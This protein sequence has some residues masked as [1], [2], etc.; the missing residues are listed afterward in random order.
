[1]G[2]PIAMATKALI[3]EDSEA[4]QTMLQ[5]SLAAVAVTADIVQ[6]AEE[7]KHF[8][9]THSVDLVV[10]DAASGGNTGLTLLDKLKPEGGD[11]A[12]RSNRR[13]Q[14]ELG[15]AIV[16]LREKSD[17]APAGN[18]LVMADLVKPFTGEELRAAFAAAAPH[19]KKIQAAVSPVSYEPAADPE[20]E[21]GRR[22]LSYGE[23]YVFFSENPKPAYE[24]LEV[25]SR[26]GYSV[27]LVTAG[28]AKVARERFGL[29]KG[30]EIFTL[31]DTAESK[32]TYPL[33]T[34][35]ATVKD[36][37]DKA[38]HPVLAIDDLDA[39]I[40]RTGLDLAFTA[41][42]EILGLRNDYRFTLLVAVDGDSLSRKDRELL[43]EMM[44][45]YRNSEK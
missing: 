6:N 33:G 27:L 45:V 23:S 24:A 21:L 36:F 3:V 25:F 8:I 9:Q 12:G 7:A 16:V 29:D 18:I 22:N 28:R 1:M 17:L 10:L 5:E 15:P 35:I 38:D 43:G 41:V 40:E 26:G 2:H 39:I 11:K 31:S 42:H 4:M 34:L 37:L 32:W 30:A 19:D 20:S 44:I 14:L 13:Q